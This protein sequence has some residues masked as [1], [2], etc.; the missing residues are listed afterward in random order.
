MQAP[1]LGLL[2][3]PEGEISIFDPEIGRRLGLQTAAYMRSKGKGKLNLAQLEEPIAYRSCSIAFMSLGSI[4]PMS[5]V[6]RRSIALW[7]YLARLSSQHCHTLF[8]RSCF[9][10]LRYLWFC[11]ISQ[12]SGARA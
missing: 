7:Y 1:F 5:L 12:A 3:Y 10:A 2:P 4:V 8:C 6:C 11:D 9:A